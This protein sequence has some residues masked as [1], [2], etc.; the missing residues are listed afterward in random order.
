MNKFKKLL[1]LILILLISLSCFGMISYAA[2]ENYLTITYDEG[3]DYCVVY[4]CNKYAIGEINIPATYNVAGKGTKTVGEIGFAAFRDAESVTK[5]TV[6][7]GVKKVGD[8]AF[9]NCYQLKEVVF[10][11]TECTIGIAAF[12]YCSGLTSITLPSGLK[13][14]PLEGFAACTSLQS[15][16]I[17]ATVTSIGKEAFRKCSALK[18]ITIPANVTSIGFNAFLNCASIESFNVEPGNQNYKAVGGV[19]FDAKGETLIQY[20]N[21][22]TATQYTVPAG[23]KT[24]GDSAFGSNTK[25]TKITL[26]SGVETINAYAFNLCT[27]LSGIN[28]PSSVKTIGPQA[29]GGCKALKEITLPA[30]LTSYS[31]AFYNSGLE[32]VILTDGIDLIDEKAFEKCASLKEVT[33]P[34]SVTEIEKGAFDGC[35]AL[36][37][38]E[39][40][41]S[42]TAIGTNAF[43]GCADI[44]LKVKNDSFAHT[45]AAEKGIRYEVLDPPVEKEIDSVEITSLPSKVAY[46]TGEKISTSGMVLTVSYNDGTKAT[47]TSGFE[48]DTQYASGTG[49]QTVKVTYKGKSDTFEIT[50]TAPVVKNVVG[51]SVSRFPDKTDY[52]YKE[53]LSTS[54]L[55]LL[56]EYDD[57]STETVSSGYTVP[58]TKFTSTGSQTITVTYRGFEAEFAVNV[59]YAWWQ[60]IIMYLFLGFLWY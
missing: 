16:E 5:V 22:K 32:T 50:V 47:V 43:R 23:V 19:L 44:T 20:P 34:E 55:K 51:V 40:P 24:I 18:E 28:L 56:V 54:G 37:T 53:S 31:G 46:T 2:G 9:E 57:G 21:G 36:E 29:F 42:V 13:T 33:I 12:R 41:E 14:I 58:A 17:P 49:T 45:Y 8:S 48:I 1:S 39:I 6:P 27:A 52:Y 30:N 59:T 10:E 7:S 4:A 11:G 25:L 60:L 15:I 35:E 38:L 3:N 26:P